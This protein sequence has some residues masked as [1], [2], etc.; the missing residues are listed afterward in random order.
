VSNLLEE[1]TSLKGML[2]MANGTINLPT[3][4]T[5]HTIKNIGAEA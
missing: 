3:R 4:I 1:R 5:E 2:N